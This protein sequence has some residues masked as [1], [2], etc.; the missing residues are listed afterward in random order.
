MIPALANN[1]TAKIR[2]VR[3]RG[4]GFTIRMKTPPPMIPNAIAPMLYMPVVKLALDADFLNW[5]SM[6]FG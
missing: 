1:S 4:P 5:D 3:S 6:Y 2:A